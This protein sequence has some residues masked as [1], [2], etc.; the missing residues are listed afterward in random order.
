MKKICNFC[1]FVW[2]KDLF[3]SHKICHGFKIPFS[4]VFPLNLILNTWNKI[5]KSIFSAQSLQFWEHLSLM[6]KTSSLK[7]FCFSFV[8]AIWMDD[9]KYAGWFLIKNRSWFRET[10][11]INKISHK[12]KKL[13]HVAKHQQGNH[14]VIIL[15][16]S[17]EFG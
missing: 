1:D 12:R 4:A 10:F 16:R 9:S 6:P 14:I 5:I 3:G 8:H 2:K 7:L 13:L 15:N 17:F 11:T